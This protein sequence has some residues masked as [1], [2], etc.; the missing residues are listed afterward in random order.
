MVLLFFLSMVVILRYIDAP[1]A[2]QEERCRAG[3]R[4]RKI[5][6]WPLLQAMAAKSVSTSPLSHPAGEKPPVAHKTELLPGGVASRRVRTVSRRVFSAASV[7]RRSARRRPRRAARAEAVSR[8]SARYMPRTDSAQRYAPTG[9]GG[10]VIIL[11]KPLENAAD[12]G[13]RFRLFRRR[14]NLRQRSRRNCRGLRRLGVAAAARDSSGRP[15]A[16]I[17]P[18]RNTSVNIRMTTLFFIVFSFREAFIRRGRSRPYCRLI[19][20]C[21]AHC[22]ALRASVP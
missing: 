5:M 4:S 20:H 8:P 12:T 11:R 3:L 1:G 19:P 14:R 22:S 16:A 2:E 13:E 9:A 18:A 21:S 17:A 15:A 7:F 10:G 6:Q